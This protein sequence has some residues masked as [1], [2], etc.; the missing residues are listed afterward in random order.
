MIVTA[1]SLTKEKEDS[2]DTSKVCS[3]EKSRVNK[4]SCGKLAVANKVYI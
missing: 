1:S 2:A 4:Y 3:N